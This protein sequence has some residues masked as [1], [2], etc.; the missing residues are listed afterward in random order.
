MPFVPTVPPTGSVPTTEMVPLDTYQ[1]T[2][3]IIH[4]DHNNFA[5][6][7]FV[8]IKWIEGAMDGETW[9][10]CNPKSRKITGAELQTAMTQTVEDLGLTVAADV[11]DVLKY[12]S[13]THLQSVGD[14]PDGSIT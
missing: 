4:L 3:F 6:N 10:H 5:E 2:D 7:S 11:Y 8:V 1:I 13:W 14:V 9:L 12:G